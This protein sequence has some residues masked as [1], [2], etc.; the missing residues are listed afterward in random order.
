MTKT[1][2]RAIVK[3]CEEQL[4]VCNTFFR[5]D[6][7]YYNLIPLKSNEKLFLSAQ[8][9][10]FILDGY[11]IR[12]FKDVSKIKAKADK[13]DEILKREKVTDRIEP[14]PIDITDW[15]TTFESLKLLGNNIIVEKDSLN[16]EE[17]EFVIGRI[18]KVF[19][20]FAYVRNFDADGIWQDEPSKIL[21]TEI[22]SITFASRYVTMFSKY[23]GELPENFII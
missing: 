11:T 22:T 12:R 23:L 19:S 7:N 17:Y 8:E 20:K 10:D 5:Y 1:E 2:I 15:K 4:K 16:D 6:N 9:D 21:Y 18:E 3:I 14:P 13:C